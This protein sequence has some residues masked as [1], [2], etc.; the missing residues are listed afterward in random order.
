MR[1]NELRRSAREIF[2]AGRPEIG[3]SPARDIE[4]TEKARIY[5]LVTTA[6]EK[7]WG[8]DILGHL[9]D[10]LVFHRLREGHLPFI[11]RRL[12]LQL[13]DRL[14]SRGISCAMDEA[15]HDYLLARGIPHLRHGAWILV[16]VFRRF[17]LFPVADLA[18]SGN[19]ERGSRI[20]IRPDTDDRLRF[21][22]VEDDGRRHEPVASLDRPFEVPVQWDDEVRTI[23]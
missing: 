20:L 13:N 6:A 23:S 1:V 8:S 9:D 16:R 7:Q 15:A 21:D 11:L 19:L 18:Q 10:L 3:F 17:V 12:M 14:A 5:Q 22:V 4:E 2:D